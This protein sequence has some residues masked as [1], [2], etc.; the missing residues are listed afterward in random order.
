MSEIMLFWE[1]Y[2]FFLFF[3]I[4]QIISNR[5]IAILSASYFEWEHKLHLPYQ[6]FW[7]KIDFS[8]LYIV[9]IANGNFYNSEHTKYVRFT[10]SV[11]V[12]YT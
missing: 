3:Y 12:L 1:M 4:F 8:G 9:P 2:C 5:Y 11:L 6:V 10:V 7:M